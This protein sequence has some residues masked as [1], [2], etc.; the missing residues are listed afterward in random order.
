MNPQG[1]QH[2]PGGWGEAWNRPP[3]THIVWREPAL[4][5]PWSQTPDLQTV[6]ESVSVGRHKLMVYGPLL[7]PP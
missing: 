2:T 1:R 6:R 5:M 7:Q 3:P 4:T